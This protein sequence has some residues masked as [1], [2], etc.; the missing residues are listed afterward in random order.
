MIYIYIYIYLFSESTQD[1]LD[2]ITEMNMWCDDLKN[3][4]ICAAK[5]HQLNDYLVSLAPSI[6]VK[7]V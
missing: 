7:Y 4:L 6:S 1:N 3:N 5:N 2:A